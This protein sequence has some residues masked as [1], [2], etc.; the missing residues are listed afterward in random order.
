MQIEIQVSSTPLSTPIAAIP[1][2]QL[3]TA[4]SVPDVWS[5]CKGG[6]LFRDSNGFVI[7]L[8][9]ANGKHHGGRSSAEKGIVGYRPVNRL[10]VE[11]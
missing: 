11:I 8:F 7:Y 9:T 3:L 2:N 5:D 6:L 1:V 4:D 10:I